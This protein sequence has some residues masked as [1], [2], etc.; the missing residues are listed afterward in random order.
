VRGIVLFDQLQDKRVIGEEHTFRVHVQGHDCPR[1]LSD[2]PL[3]DQLVVQRHLD[4][5]H[6]AVRMDAAFVVVPNAY[7]RHRR[8]LATREKK[9]HQKKDKKKR[10][11]KKKK[12]IKNHCSGFLAEGVHDL[13]NQSQTKKV[14]SLLTL[15]KSRYMKWLSPSWNGANH[16]CRSSHVKLCPSINFST[17]KEEEK[18]GGRE[19]RNGGR[20]GRREGGKEGRREGGKEGF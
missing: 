20:E 4:I 14:R 18:E 13:K 7:H 1:R 19:G 5:P 3:E 6:A 15:S 9:K 2:F 12:T 11:K 17:E 10:K 16:A 8:F